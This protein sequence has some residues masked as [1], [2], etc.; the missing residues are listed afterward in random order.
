MDDLKRKMKEDADEFERKFEGDEENEIF[1][2]RYAIYKPG[3]SDTQFT[4]LN[5]ILP[6]LPESYTKCLKKYNIFDITLGYFDLTP[7]SGGSANIVES[8]IRAQ[9]VEESFLPRAM[10]DP[11]DL[12]W[13]GYNE[14]NTVYVAGKNSPSYLEGEIVFIFECIL[15]AEGKLCENYQSLLAKD[16]EQFLIIAGNLNEVHRL[17]YESDLAKKEMLE[18]LKALDVD[19]KY[20]ETWLEYL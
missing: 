20:H 16:F 3:I 5:E 9:S 12:Y 4:H 8:L 14:G 15:D 19:E 1:I 2:K 18:R 10:L 17:D 7:V 6:E 13:I 11:L